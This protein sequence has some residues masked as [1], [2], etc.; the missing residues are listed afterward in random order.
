M[1]LFN[2]D[3]VKNSY[4]YSPDLIMLYHMTVIPSIH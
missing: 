3:N 2:L 4:G 1:L